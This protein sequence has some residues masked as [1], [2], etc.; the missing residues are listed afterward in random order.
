[1]QG[2][3]MGGIGKGIFGI[4]EKFAAISQHLWAKA[5]SLGFLLM[6]PCYHHGTMPCLKACENLL[7]NILKII[8]TTFCHYF[9]YIVDQFFIPELAEPIPGLFTI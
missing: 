5:K 9:A 4:I 6:G 1:M 8:N 3:W 2:I 7:K